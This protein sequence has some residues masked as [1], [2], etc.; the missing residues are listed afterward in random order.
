MEYTDTIRKRKLF[1]L[2][3]LILLVARLVANMLMPLFDPSE[4]R[5]ALICKLMAESNNFL[6][7]K[8]IHEGALINFEGKPPLYFQMGA[9]CCKIFGINLFSVRLPATLFATIII[10]GL[11]GTVRRLK[12]EPTAMLAVFLLLINPVFSFFSGAVF[13]DM[14]LTCAVSCAGFAYMIFE[15]SEP[16]SKERRFSSM[17]FFA[18]F[19]VGMLVKGP[20]ILV[21]GGLPVFTYVLINRRWK[22]LRDHAWFSGTAIFLLIAAPWYILMQMKNPEFFE[23]FFVNENFKRFLFKDYGDQYG[24]GRESFHG[25]AVILTLAV[26]TPLY[27]LAALPCMQKANRKALFSS[28]MIHSP[29]TGIAILVVLCITG[30]WCLTSRVLITYLLPTAPFFALTIAVWLTKCNEP[31]MRRIAAKQTKTIATCFILIIQ[32]TFAA[33]LFVADS[34]IAAM[35]GAFFKRI[36]KEY[37]DGQFYFYKKIP[38]SAYYYLEGRVVPHPDEDVSESQEKAK[39]YYFISNKK[40][41]DRYPIPNA[42]P[43]LSESGK[44]VLMDRSEKQ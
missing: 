12:D 43:V 44:W 35:P 31:V 16:R 21:M 38:Y 8:L 26:N 14:A 9:I 42:P 34:Q 24:A 1:F 33:T 4:S 11:Y 22:E 6:E 29:L 18:A 23:Y 2:F 20:V 41:I 25:M 32:V 13:T 7:P 10:L 3:L 17:F 30:F 19:A 37:P 36:A 40:Y 5:Y 39:P 28:D 27:L 15:A